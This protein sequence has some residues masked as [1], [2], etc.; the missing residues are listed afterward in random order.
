MRALMW[1]SDF[2]TRHPV[3]VALVIYLSMFVGALIMHI[4]A[5]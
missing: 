3:I 5:S 2:L 1:M 4:I